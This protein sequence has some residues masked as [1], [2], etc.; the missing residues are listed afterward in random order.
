M[1]NEYRILLYKNDTHIVSM[2]G[3]LRKVSEKRQNTMNIIAVSRTIRKKCFLPRAN[4]SAPG[5]MDLTRIP[6]ISGKI[7]LRKILK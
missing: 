1:H 7:T 6:T 4:K 3:G 5:A 2:F